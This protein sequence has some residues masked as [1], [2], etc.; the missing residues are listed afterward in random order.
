MTAIIPQFSH[1]CVLN[2]AYN[3]AHELDANDCPP[4]CVFPRP[5]RPYEELFHEDTG[6]EFENELHRLYVE[7]SVRFRVK[8]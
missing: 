3:T 7:G 1:E 6:G 2:Q 5:P 8:A 4:E